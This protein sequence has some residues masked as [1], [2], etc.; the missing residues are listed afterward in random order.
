MWLPRILSQQDRAREEDEGE[1][2]MFSGRGKNLVA[3]NSQQQCLFSETN[4]ISPRPTAT[5]KKKTCILLD[6][7]KLSITN[8]GKAID[9]RLWK[10]RGSDPFA[11]SRGISA[12][13]SFAAASPAGG[14]AKTLR[15]YLFG[16]WGGKTSWI[17]K[18][19]ADFFRAPVWPIYEKLS[20]RLSASLFHP[21]RI[22]PTAIPDIRDDLL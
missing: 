13:D 5:E 8:R 12:W 2:E 15:L 1:R 21:R 7:I 22:L 9:Y 20:P 19:A 4:I 3:R 16:R 11:K 6:I 17:Y 14:G 18:M 10:T